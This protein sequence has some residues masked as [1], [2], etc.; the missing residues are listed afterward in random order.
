MMKQTQHFWEIPCHP[1]MQLSAETPSERKSA[2]VAFFFFLATP[3]GKFAANLGAR[4]RRATPKNM[5]C[6]L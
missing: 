4:C 6:K 5:A 2:C 1:S 3:A